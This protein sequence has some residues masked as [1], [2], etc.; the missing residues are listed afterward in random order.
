MLGETFT[1]SQIKRLFN[2]RAQFRT[3]RIKSAK[4]KI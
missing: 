2:F 1:V 3:D 4:P